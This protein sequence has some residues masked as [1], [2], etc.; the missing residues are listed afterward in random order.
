MH[1]RI[2]LVR[3]CP[4]LSAAAEGV[5]WWHRWIARGGERL[6][7]PRVVGEG[8]EAWW[9]VALDRLCDL[10]AMIERMEAVG[11]RLTRT[12]DQRNLAMAEIAGIE[13]E[14]L[15]WLVS[16]V[17]TRWRSDTGAAGWRFPPDGW[18]HAA[19]VAEFQLRLR[20]YPLRLRGRRESG[21]GD[22]NDIGRY[23][24]DSARWCDYLARSTEDAARPIPKPF[25]ALT[26]AREVNPEHMQLLEAQ[27]ELNRAVFLRHAEVLEAHKH[28]EGTSGIARLF[29]DPDLNSC[30]DGVV[31]F[32]QIHKGEKGSPEQNARA[33]WSLAQHLA[34]REGQYAS[35]S[36]V[37]SATAGRRW[38][39]S[40]DRP[41]QWLNEMS[42]DA[43]EEGVRLELAPRRGVY[44]DK[45]TSELIDR[46]FAE[47]DEVVL[48]SGTWKVV[49][50][51][52]VVQS[53]SHR[54]DLQFG[55]HRS[56]N[57]LMVEVDPAEIPAGTPIVP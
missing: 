33:D 6:A 3:Q 35:Y 10:E 20:K 31:V 51:C 27:E 25:A 19:V 5:C 14:A 39:A 56:H 28:Q 34:L 43:E 4:R 40:L 15:P 2:C 7:D 32:H 13:E 37:R 24:R 54:S 38:L 23:A 42:P 12:H 53:D 46:H 55:A 29:G 18:L 30:L 26:V 8:F 22:V 49:R 48:P 41:P 11:V 16:R 44:L 57:I 50:H 1:A 36:H 45:A 52:D 21:S 9:P 47:E 17:L